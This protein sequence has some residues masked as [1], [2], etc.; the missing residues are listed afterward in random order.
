MLLPRL[1][2]LLLRPLP[3]AVGSHSAGTQQQGLSAGMV[4]LLGLSKGQ[5]CLVL[6]CGWRSCVTLQQEAWHQLAAQDY[7]LQ[8]LQMRLLLLPWLQVGA[9]GLIAC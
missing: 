7:L 3:S 4:L 1:Q 8:Q 5:C 6:C 2:T 9:P